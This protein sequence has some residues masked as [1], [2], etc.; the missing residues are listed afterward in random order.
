MNRRAVFGK[1]GK[2]AVILIFALGDLV[3]K[4]P[5]QLRQTFN[6][7]LMGFGTYF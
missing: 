5:W 2:A 4:H 3:L 6:G 7:P 1:L